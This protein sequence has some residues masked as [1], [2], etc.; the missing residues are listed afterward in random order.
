ME[1]KRSVILLSGLLLL[2]IF[3][4]WAQT[5]DTAKPTCPPASDFLTQAM[6]IPTAWVRADWNANTSRWEIDCTQMDAIANMPSH[7]PSN[8]YNT[9]TN[10]MTNAVPS[11]RGPRG[12]S[13]YVNTNPYRSN[14]NISESANAAANIA[15]NSNAKPANRRRP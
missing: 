1:A 5:S 10:S 11:R 9:T 4:G 14:Y 13:N 6:L 2:M 8:M 15:A 7:L 3:V 12:N